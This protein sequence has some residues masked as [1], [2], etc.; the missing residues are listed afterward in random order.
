MTSFDSLFCSQERM[1]ALR[2][3]LF[4]SNQYFTEAELEKSLSKKTLNS[5]RTL[6]ELERLGAIKK[7][8]N[9]DTSEFVYRANTHWLLYDEFRTLFVKAQLL[10]ENDLERKLPKL[11]SIRLFVLTGMFVG[12]H[13]A[14]TDILVVGKINQ[15]VLA[16]FI[17]NFESEI[18]QEVNYTCLTLPEYQFRRNVGDRFLHNVTDSKHVVIADYLESAPPVE[19]DMSPSVKLSPPKNNSKSTVVKKNKVQK[20]KPTS[21]QKKKAIKKPIPRRK[22]INKKTAKKKVLKRKR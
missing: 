14:P 17:A 21:V 5:G 6:R 20:S 22:I 7:L 3:L 10:I 8:R 19:G 16:N 11:G 2:F 12:D 18:G 9:S 1:A 13:G 4:R 15:R